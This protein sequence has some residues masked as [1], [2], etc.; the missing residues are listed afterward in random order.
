MK[1]EIERKFLLKAIP[2]I[3]PEETI[4]IF[5]WYRKNSKGIWERA[6]SCYS[7]KKGFI[8]YTLLKRLSEK[9]LM[10]KMKNYNI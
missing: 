2:E 6:R 1:I 4:E 10:K 9:E 3:A 7:D 5:Q 8:L